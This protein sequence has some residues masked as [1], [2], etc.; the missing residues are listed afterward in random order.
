MN[1]NDHSNIAVLANELSNEKN[2]KKWKKDV[3]YCRDQKV[4]QEIFLLHE[5]IVFMKY[6]KRKLLK[7]IDFARNLNMKVKQCLN[8]K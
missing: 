8:I 1:Y 2:G 3:R 5:M 6:Y 4:I 7:A